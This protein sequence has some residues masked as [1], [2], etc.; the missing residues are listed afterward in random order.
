MRSEAVSVLSIHQ[1]RD[2]ASGRRHSAAAATGTQSV[3]KPTVDM[4]TNDSRTV[5]ACARTRQ[6]PALR[7][8]FR[9]FRTAHPAH[10]RL[11]CSGLQL[12]HESG[13]SFHNLHYANGLNAVQT[14]PMPPIARRWPV[15]GVLSPATP[16]RADASGRPG[17]ARRGGGAASAGH[18]RVPMPGGPEIGR[19]A[20]TVPEPSR[21][22]SEVGVSH[23]DIFRPEPRGVAVR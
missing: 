17:T 23:A 19:R 22:T 8:G 6:K 20:P 16:A 12:R 21:M 14:P 15:A 18:G 10:A 7:L 3:A 13:R 4:S 2:K 5:V 11:P 1:D 9:A